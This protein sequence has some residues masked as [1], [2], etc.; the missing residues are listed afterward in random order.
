MSEEKSLLDIIKSEVKSS[1]PS[2]R[3]KAKKKEEPAKP[4]TYNREHHEIKIT[5]L[6]DFENHPFKVEENRDMEALME[7]IR[8]NGVMTPILVRK[9]KKQELDVYEI[10]SGHRRKFACEKLG[11]ETIPAE[12]ILDCNETLETYIEDED[13]FLLKVKMC[14]P[15]CFQSLKGES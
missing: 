7:S 9:V 15:S 6:K 4:I 8:A 11:I 14:V 2:K 5:E 13:K 10:I 1:K 3:S 12:L